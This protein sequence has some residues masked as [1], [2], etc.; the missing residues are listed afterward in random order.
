MG[1]HAFDPGRFSQRGVGG[2]HPRLLDVTVATP[3]AEEPVTLTEAR[4]WLRVDGTD[5]DT[6]ITALIVAAREWAEGYTRRA[7]VNRD[8]AVTFA[9][10][11]FVGVDMYLPF[12]PGTALTALTYV[13]GDGTAQ[14]FDI[15]DTT[16]EED[17]GLLRVNGDA[18]ED[19][20]Q[21]VFSVLAEYTGGYGP[22]ASTVP[23]EVKTAIKIALAQMFEVRVD[24]TFGAQASVPQTKASMALLQHFRVWDL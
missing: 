21:S 15:A 3:P 24:Q 10:F 20:P 6:V 23:E 5:Q 7:F 19:W 16:L 12:P 9:H 4:D 11:P 2:D 22:D 1:L 13:D 8:L 17:T 14:V 18:V